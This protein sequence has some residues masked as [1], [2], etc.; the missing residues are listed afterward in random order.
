M[1]CQFSSPQAQATGTAATS[2][3]IGTPV[4]MATATRWATDRGSGSKS[5][6]GPW[7][8]SGWAWSGETTGASVGAVSTVPRWLEGPVSGSKAGQMSVPHNR[9]HGP[10]EYAYVTVAYGTVGSARPPR[11]ISDRFRPVRLVA[12]RQP[13]Q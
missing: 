2:A 10:S 4:K 9:G 11:A 3:S 5:G 6:S 12:F 13:A 7:R 1:V 8:R